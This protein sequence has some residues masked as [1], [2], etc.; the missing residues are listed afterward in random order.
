[1][2]SNGFLAIQSGINPQNI[3]D[4]LVEQL[5][6]ESSGSTGGESRDA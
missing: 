2:I 5:S 3:K 6:K 4:Y 1:M